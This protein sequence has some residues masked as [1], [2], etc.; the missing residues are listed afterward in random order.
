MWPWRLPRTFRRSLQEALEYWVHEPNFISNYQTLVQAMERR[1]SYILPFGFPLFPDLWRGCPLHKIQSFI[2]IIGR[3]LSNTKFSFH[4]IYI[5][6]DGWC[7]C[8]SFRLMIMDFWTLIILLPFLLLFIS[9]WAT[10]PT[11]SQ[12]HISRLKIILFSC[13]FCKYLFCHV[14]KV[15]DDNA[16]RLQVRWT[17]AIFMK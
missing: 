16:N 2:C 11:S 13:W 10:I 14:K 4:W 5:W 7:G 1:Y 6:L 3:P 15:F 12:G 8:T 17:N 9:I